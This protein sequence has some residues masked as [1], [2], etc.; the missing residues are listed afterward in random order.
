VF[1]V[2]TLKLSRK[3]GKRKLILEKVGRKKGK[4]KA[5]RKTAVAVGES[6]TK[7]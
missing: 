2:A 5:R 1:I 3:F 4:I 7:T 6:S